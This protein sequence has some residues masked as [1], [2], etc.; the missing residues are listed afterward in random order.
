MKVAKALLITAL[1]IGWTQVS[2][3]EALRV[4]PASRL[5]QEALAKVGS[6]VLIDENYPTPGRGDRQRSIEL[7]HLKRIP[8]IRGKHYVTWLRS[9]KD[10]CL[11]EKKKLLTTGLGIKHPEVVLLADRIGIASYLIQSA[12]EGGVNRQP[13]D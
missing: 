2:W 3:S 13:P 11:A 12:D 9:H 7:T 10:H 6:Q 5:V 1:L 8:N 4:H